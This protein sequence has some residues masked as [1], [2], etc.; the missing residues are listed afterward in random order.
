MTCLYRLDMEQTDNTVLRLTTLQV[1]E[2]QL[3]LSWS[4]VTWCG[5]RSLDG[6]R[7]LIASAA[8]GKSLYQS[9]WEC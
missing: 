8:T 9:E 1:L 7:L 4:L 6:I 5:R 2:R 3:S